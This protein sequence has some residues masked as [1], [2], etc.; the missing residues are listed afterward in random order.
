MI[1]F[2]CLIRIYGVSLV[3]EEKFY[4]FVN[5]DETRKEENEPGEEPGAPARFVEKVSVILFIG[6]RSGCA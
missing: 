3:I 1:M 4:S 6:G 2:D 5:E